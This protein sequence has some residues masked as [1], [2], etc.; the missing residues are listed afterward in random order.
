MEAGGIITVRHEWGQSQIKG[1]TP[2]SKAIV[3]KEGNGRPLPTV[4]HRFED[5]RAEIFKN[6][7][8][9]ALVQELAEWALAHGLVG[10]CAEMLDKLV[11]LKKTLPAAEAYA[12][13]RDELKR[14]PEKNTSLAAVRNKLLDGYQVVEK[15]GDHYALVHSPRSGTAKEMEKA[16]ETLENAFRGYYYWWAL[17]GIAQSVPREVQVAVMTDS[18]DDLRRFHN[19]LT[20][21]P[22]VGDG[23]FARREGGTVLANRR[24]DEPYDVLDKFSSYWWQ[25]GYNRDLLL[26]GSKAGRPK[27]PPSANPQE[28]QIE[29]VNAQMLALL[30]KAMEREG[31]LATVTHNASRQLLFASGLLPRNVT[32]PEWF[33]FGMGSF[34]ETPYQSPWAGVGAP[35]F[36][37]L[38]R[39]KEMKKGD[40]EPHFEKTP[41]ATL[42]AVVTDSYFRNLP[43][44]GDPDTPARKAHDEAL[45]KARAA[46]W[47][48]AYYLAKERIDGLQ[49]YCKELG[50]LP[51]DLELDE[52]TLLETF[53]RALGA[54]NKDNMPDDAQLTKLANAWFYFLD[55]VTLESETMRNE[56]EK[57]YKENLLATRPTPGGNTGG[58][59][60][61]GGGP[62]RPGGGPG[63]PGG[64]PGG[65]NNPGGS[66]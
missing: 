20:S 36:Y 54:V 23:F 9:P 19:L 4:A 16:L 11:E 3:L 25:K 1:V 64:G 6:E 37:W 35:S 59:A 47:G 12:K 45:R 24:L 61:P 5:K 34:F 29:F 33:L 27:T 55:N 41:L 58:P 10:K 46:S 43:A 8:N 65:G 31:R 18:T 15:P 28:E 51:R 44:P 56:I 52:Q 39:F 57:F 60:G 21:G 32:A 48:L 50:K 26:T 13:V 38:P 2:I 63:R 66:Q 53:A 49:R 14:A 7:P 30:L 40:K 17:R 22:M 42:K 62:G